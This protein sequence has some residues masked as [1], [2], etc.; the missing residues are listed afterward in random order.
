VLI[1]GGE[2]ALIVMF[3][4]DKALIAEHIAYLRLKRNEKGK[5]YKS[6]LAP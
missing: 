2:T 3:W 6:G 5:Y 4:L 1:L